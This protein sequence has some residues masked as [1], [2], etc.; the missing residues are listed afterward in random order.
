MKSGVIENGIIKDENSLSQAIKLVCDSAKGGKLKT[1]YVVC[2]LPE[3]ESF[4][5]VIQMP[6]MNEGELK[7]A[8]S[9]EVENYIPLPI[10]QVYWDFQIIIPLQNASNRCDVLVAAIAKQTADTYLS[11]LKKAGLIPLVFEVKAQSVA[12]AL[13]AGK[14]G[15]Q[16]VI[17][18]DIG[19]NSTDFIIFSDH[20]LRFTFLIPIYSSY[21]T[22]SIAKSLN[23]SAQKAE[24]LKLR[25]GFSGKRGNE[26]EAVS[27]G[28]RSALEEFASSVK[29]R[30]D[31]YREHTAREHPLSRTSIKKIILCGGGADLKGLPEFLSQKIGIPT[32][33]GDVFVNIGPRPKK[34]D[35]GKVGYPSFAACL[36]LAQR[37]AGVEEYQRFKAS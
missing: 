27:K 5:Q 14:T 8:L 35:E 25:H 33:I 37:A 30:I 16:P 29:E 15:D 1:K 28:L 22:N 19:E 36:G 13:I 31:F 17:L 24:E 3:E 34:G 11:C 6:K 10:D 20:S 2:S 9:F 12:R 18:L 7:S 26:S 4:L 21:F 32:E 23:I